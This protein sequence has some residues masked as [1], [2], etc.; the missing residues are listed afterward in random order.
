MDMKATRFWE[1][2]KN[3]ETMEDV[4]YMQPCL[5]DGLSNE[6]IL[7]LRAERAGLSMEDARA[8]EAALKTI[9]T[10]ENKRVG[11]QLRNAN[12]VILNLI[13]N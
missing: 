6:Q 3:C 2:L 13:A 5:V 11:E 12:K 1:L 10:I 7:Q 4:F 8:Y 9:K